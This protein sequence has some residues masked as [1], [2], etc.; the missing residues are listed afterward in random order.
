MK[1][2]IDIDENM[3]EPADEPIVTI[4]CRT[5]DDRVVRLQKAMTGAL[6][7]DVRIRLTRDGREYYLPPEDILFFESEGGRTYAHTGGEVF[8][9]KL[10]LY[11]LEGLLPQSFIRIS[12]S[13]IAGTD[14]IYSIDKN[15]VGPSTIQFRNSHKKLSVSRQYFKILHDKLN[16]E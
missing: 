14:K 9:S 13:A 3:D 6:A 12:K 15:P 10:R 5:V 4:R 16:R 2:R 11:E 8:E 1:I 7:D